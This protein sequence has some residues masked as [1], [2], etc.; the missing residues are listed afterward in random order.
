MENIRVKDYFQ[1]GDGITNLTVNGECA[2]CGECC[3]DILPMDHNEVAKIKKYV[4]RN[5]IQQQDHRLPTGV[6]DCACPF[7][8]IDTKKCM[9]YPVRPKICRE[10]LCSKTEEE[11]AAVRTEKLKIGKTMSMRMAGFG[12]DSQML[13]MA[14]ALQNLLG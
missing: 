10:F 8:N 11:I 7:L 9:I 13:L 4:Q 2:K 5:H 1:R 14:M 3:S 12:D 6:A